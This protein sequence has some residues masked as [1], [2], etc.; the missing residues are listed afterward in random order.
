MPMASASMLTCEPILP[1]PMMPNFLPLSSKLPFASLFQTPSCA[2]LFLSKTFL[3]KMIEAP[4]TNSAT[5][6]VLLYGAL[7]TTTPLSAQ[8]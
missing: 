5:D 3:I 8:L 7:K 2:A 1:Y 6:R 4:I